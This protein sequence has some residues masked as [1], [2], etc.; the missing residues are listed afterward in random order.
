MDLRT[1]IKEIQLYYNLRYPD[2]TLKVVLLYLDKLNPNLDKLYDMSILTF[3]GKYKSLPYVSDFN[4]MV[5]K[6]NDNKKILIQNSKRYTPPDN[7][8][9]AAI[10]KRHYADLEA[11]NE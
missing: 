6:I 5:K 10:V 2:N 1:F 11:N 9:I 7:P 3:S 4:D 8:G